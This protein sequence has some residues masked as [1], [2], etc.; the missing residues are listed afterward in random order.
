VCTK[1]QQF[2]LIKQQLEQEVLTRGWRWNG[3]DHFYTWPNKA[4]LHVLSADSNWEQIQ[5]IPLDLVGFDEHPPRKLWTELM[6]RRRGKR[7]TRYMVAATMTLGMTWFVRDMIQ[8]WEDF[9]VEQGVPPFEARMRQLHPEIWCWNVGGLRD[10]PVMTEE[11]FQHYESQSN[12]SEKELQVRL[13]GG[14][15]DFSGESVFDRDALDKMVADIEP[16]Q[17]GALNQ[18]DGNEPQ[19]IMPDGRDAEEILKYRR[20]TGYTNGKYVN[21]HPD[22]DV[23]GG[24]IRVF[25]PPEA[26]GQYVMGADFAA[27]LVGRDFDVCQVLMK[28]E[29]GRLE[30]VAIGRGW[31]GDVDF[32]SV[33]FNL[34]TWYMN[35]FLCGERQFGLPTMRRLYDEMSYTWILRNRHES[36]RSRRMSDTLGHH[37]HAGDTIIPN[38]ATAIKNGDLVVHDQETIEELRQYQWRPKNKSVDRDMAKSEHLTTGAPDG[39]HDDCVMALAYSVHASREVGKVSLPKPGYRPGTFGAIFRPDK[40]LKPPRRVVR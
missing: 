3:S 12:V 28:R 35:A 19:I 21:F 4:K 33:I 39:M 8:A 37:R 7:K 24:T 10:N 27:G 30:Q 25:R 9:H 13:R 40:H 38:L 1:Y 16:G 14:Y 31:W 17:E 11:D 26:G 36:T 20:V 18:K 15:A 22:M 2:E 5:G 23:E 6:F 34:G 29:D 32:A